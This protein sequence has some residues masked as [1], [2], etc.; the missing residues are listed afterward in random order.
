MTTEQTCSRNM[1]AQQNQ[2]T[3]RHTVAQERCPGGPTW[4][5]LG[6]APP[7]PQIASDLR[8]AIRITNRNRNQIARLGARTMLPRMIACLIPEVLK[9]KWVKV[10]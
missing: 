9:I 5:W 10:L 3:S 6:T 4:S 1:S 2:H 8:F 7:L